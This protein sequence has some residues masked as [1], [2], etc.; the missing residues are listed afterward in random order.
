M[1]LNKSSVEK[2]MNW[3]KLS[4]QELKDFIDLVRSPHL[5]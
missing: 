3:N 1:D 5:C 4:T 2:T